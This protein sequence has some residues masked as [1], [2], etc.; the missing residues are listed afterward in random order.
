MENKE[1][2][3]TDFSFLLLDFY[4]WTALKNMEYQENISL[5]R[6]KAS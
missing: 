1:I 6:T 4:L 3:V 2:I 5:G